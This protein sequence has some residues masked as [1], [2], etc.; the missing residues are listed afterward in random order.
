MAEYSLP[1]LR[2]LR[3]MFHERLIDRRIVSRRPVYLEG[4]YLQSPCPKDAGTPR[5]GTLTDFAEVLVPDQDDAVLTGRQD[6]LQ[7]GPQN[8]LSD[9]NGKVFDDIRGLYARLLMEGA[10][11]TYERDET[12]ETRE[13]SELD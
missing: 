7:L 10:F 8:R 3:P 5:E 12:P 6:W 2:A 4:V 1:Q 9:E 11:R 13:A